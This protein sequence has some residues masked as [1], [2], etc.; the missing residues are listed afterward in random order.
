MPPQFCS[1]GALIATALTLYNYLTP[2][3]GV[4]GTEG[5][6][7]VVVSSILLV[8]AGAILWFRSYGGVFW[9]FWVLSLLGII[10]TAAAGYFL[11]EWLLLAAMAVTFIGLVVLLFRRPSRAA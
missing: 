5:A 1:L 11:H 4:T 8:I 2:M 6:L 10:G 9:L 7:L 3:T